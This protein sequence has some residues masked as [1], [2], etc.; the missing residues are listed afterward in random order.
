MNQYPYTSQGI[1][2]LV[3]QVAGDAI[4]QVFIEKKN[5]RNYDYVRSTKFALFG[6]INGLVIYKW[7]SFLD[8][9]IN[10]PSKFATVMYKLAGKKRPL[11][12]AG[13]L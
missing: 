1:V 8:E 7:Y 12:G 9:K 6:V 10:Y 5:W 3:L 11:T 2:S 13:S 4:A